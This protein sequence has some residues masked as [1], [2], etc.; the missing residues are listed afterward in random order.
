MLLLKGRTFIALAV[1][2]ICFAFCAPNFTTCSSI[3]LMIKHASIYGLPALDNYM[4]WEV[5]RHS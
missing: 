3:V 5:C 2:V 1:L 4:G